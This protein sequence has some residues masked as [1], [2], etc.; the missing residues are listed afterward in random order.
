PTTGL[1]PPQIL[2]PTRQ[3]NCLVALALVHKLGRRQLKVARPYATQQTVR[4]VAADLQ[5]I[6]ASE[7]HSFAQN[8]PEHR[9][10]MNIW[11]ADAD[12]LQLRLRATASDDLIIDREHAPR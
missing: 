1:H 8:P 9:R 7:C 12:D 4:M 3:G 11:N 2:H 6:M 5:P 10:R